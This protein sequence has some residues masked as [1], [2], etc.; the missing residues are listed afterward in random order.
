MAKMAMEND[1]K[2]KKTTRKKVDKKKKEVKEVGEN[3]ELEEIKIKNMKQDIDS[4]LKVIEVK[5][6][7]KKS[8]KEEHSLFRLWEVIVVM[9]VTLLVGLFIGSYAT[10]NKYVSDDNHN[11]SNEIEDV[12]SVY[13]DIIRDY[14]KEVE[15]AKLNDYAILGMLS[16]LEDNNS[17][18]ID[19]Y[20]AQEIDSEL[21]GS[22]IGLGVEITR[23]EDNNIEIVSVY[24]NSPAAKSDIRVGDI[25]VE[26]DSKKYDASTTNEMTYKIKNSK[27]GDTVSIT[28]ERGKDNLTKKIKLEQVELQSVFY[29][30]DIDGDDK[31][32]IIT[33]S[34]FALNTYKQ[35]EKA[36]NELKEKGVKSL[37]IDLRNNAG[38]YLSSA[39]KVLSL[40]L[41]K[42]DVVYQRSSAD[43]VEKIINDSDKV[44]TIPVVLL[45]NENTA[46]SAE[47]FVSSM[48]ENLGVK[49][50]GTKTYGKGTIQKMYE[51][52]DGRYVKF[53]VQEWLTAKGNKVDGVGIVPDFSI[54]NDVNSPVDHQLEKALELAKNN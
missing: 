12:Y 49:V 15:P 19:K 43:T 8:R 50:V 46:S 26:V 33:I 6:K 52:S 42:G 27:I 9:I 45:V 2:K 34:N 24:N 21:N 23:N 32:G 22:Y 14:Y 44:I 37:V 25:I 53:T 35:L 51:L 18:L 5:D 40:F 36:Y 4:D 39:S 13:K 7:K 10:Y 31:V 48:V 47:I 1:N 16:S 11:T 20:S 38:G 41:S 28:V 54:Q 17:S 3:K 30:L 29:T